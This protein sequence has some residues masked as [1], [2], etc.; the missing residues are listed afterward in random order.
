MDNGKVE[1]FHFHDPEMLIQTHSPA[2]Q[3]EEALTA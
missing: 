1:T 2:R 3:P